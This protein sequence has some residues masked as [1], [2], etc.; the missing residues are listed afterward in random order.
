MQKLLK[1][2][3]PLFTPDSLDQ[4]TL[5]FQSYGTQGNVTST[6]S[7]PPLTFPGDKARYPLGLG[8]SRVWLCC[9]DGSD[10]Q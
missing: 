9:E 3:N 1:Q 4:A 2:L 6:V 5:V 8:G 10:P 7:R